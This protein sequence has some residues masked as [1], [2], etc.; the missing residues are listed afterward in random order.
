MWTE[1]GKP[2][3]GAAYRRLGPGRGS[4]VPAPDTRSGA[5]LKGGQRPGT[6]VGDLVGAK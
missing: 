1:G 3:V 6:G 5:F 4:E 2:E